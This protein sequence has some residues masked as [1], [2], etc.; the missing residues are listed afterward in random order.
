MTSRS[1][2]AGMPAMTG[3]IGIENREVEAA[4]AGAGERAD[5]RAVTK[6]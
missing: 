5:L 6:E 3:A 2:K 1:S 4:R